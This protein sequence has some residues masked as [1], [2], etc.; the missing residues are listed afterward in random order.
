MNAVAGAPRN[1]GPNWGCTFLLYVERCLPRWLFRPALMVGA[2]GAL[3]RMSEA[4]A[5]SRAFLAVVLGRAPRP[6]EQWRHFFAFAEVLVLK[7]RAGGG[8]PNV[9]KISLSHSGRE[10]RLCCL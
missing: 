5:H 1:P 6:A 7:L 9:T 2:W 10:R 8:A 3:A 4:R